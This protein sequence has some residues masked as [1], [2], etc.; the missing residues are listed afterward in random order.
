MIRVTVELVSAR[1]GLITH[2]GSATISND[3]S[4]TPVLGNY[5]FKFFKR[6]KARQIW[7]VG[8]IRGFPRKRL[9][10]WDLLYLVLK[11]VV[12]QRNGESNS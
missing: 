3:G 4:G 11:E 1:T 2:L 5:G 6:G 8:A 10:V 12:G 9:L 7:K